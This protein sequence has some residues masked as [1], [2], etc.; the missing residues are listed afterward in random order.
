MSTAAAPVTQKVS[1][2]KRIGQFFGKVL[3]IV[4]TDAK[5]IEQIAVPVAEALLPQFVP[6]I[7]TADGIFSAIVKEAVAAESAAAAVGQAAGTGAAKLAA[8]LTNIGPVI[9]NWV[10]SNFPGASQISAVAKSGLI[11]AVVAIVNEIDGTGIAAGT[12]VAAAPAATM[13][14]VGSGSQ[15]TATVG[16]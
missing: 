4:A 16:S 9:D 5:P 10:A 8:A 2:L 1:W 11:S 12:G 6:L 7:A 3:G 14:P 13:T 15:V